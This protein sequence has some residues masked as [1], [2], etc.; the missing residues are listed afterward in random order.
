[1]RSAGITVCNWSNTKRSTFVTRCFKQS[2]KSFLFLARECV[3]KQICF[4]GYN[5][6]TVLSY[7]AL[8]VFLNFLAALLRKSYLK[9][10][11]ASVKTL[12]NSKKH[13]SNPLQWAC[14]GI[15]KTAGDGPDS[16]VPPPMTC[17]PSR[18]FPAS[19]DGWKPEKFTNDRER[20]AEIEFWCCFRYSKIFRTSMY[21][22]GSKQNFPKKAAWNIENQQCMCRKYRFDLSDL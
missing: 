1:M 2:R 12:T 5:I 11:L 22:Y 4:V 3:T 13:F 7:C 15:Q 9:F 10:R 18:I 8:V 14:C 17:M 6:K 20:E 21:F 19:Y 16:I